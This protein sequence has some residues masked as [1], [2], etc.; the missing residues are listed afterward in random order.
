MSF[1]SKLTGF[2]GS[3]LKYGGPALAAVGQVQ[4]DLGK[5]GGNPIVQ[6][7]KKAQAI[8]LV[9]AATHA[10]ETVPNSTVQNVAGVVEFSVGLAQGLGL[11]GKELKQD[12]SI[13]IP[14]D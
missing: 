7:S 13:S 12:A 11:F 1:L 8:A 14:K 2:A 9:L 10:G 4:Q 3:L 6:Q 5:S